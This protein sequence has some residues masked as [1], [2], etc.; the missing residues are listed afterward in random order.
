MGQRL[1]PVLAVCF[2]SKIEEPVLTRRPLM[3]WR[4]IEDCF[5]VTSTQSEM[6]ECFKTLNEQSQYISLTREKPHDGWLPYL[7][8]QVMLAN[9]AVHIKWYRKES[10]KNIILHATSAHPTAV[11]RAVIRNMFKTASSVCSGES[12]RLESLEM[13]RV[14][15][16]N[17]GYS[18]QSK[19]SKRT[20][21]NA[22]NQSRT[23]VPLCLPFICD[24]VT[25]AVKRCI[26]QAQ[27][28]NDVVL[29]NLPQDNIK[30]QLVRNRLYDR[31]CTSQ[32]CIV[33]TNGRSGD[34]SKSGVVYQLECRTCRAIYI[35][36]TGRPLFVRVNEHLA[37]K[38]RQGL[39]SP[40][41]K[42]RRENHG[43]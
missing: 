35:G 10:S 20:Y 38:R 32:N 30:K 12:E 11:K 31:A 7:N 18:L 25:N 27:L 37:S 29:V 24:K 5:I 36:E 21:M 6:D 14:I 43:S 17:N 15:A 33:C 13:A 22:S 41:G 19:A 40:L 26:T 34:C 9:G 16:S 3:Y 1:A 28:D 8:T 4:Y 2:M 23:R 42:H 39:V